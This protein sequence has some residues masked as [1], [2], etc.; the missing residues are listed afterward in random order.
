MSTMRT[1]KRAMLRNS[2]LP[3]RA[4]K[5]IA[6]KSRLYLDVTKRTDGNRGGNRGKK[7]GR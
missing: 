2:G 1:I 6:N 5:E 3:K 7:Y 4:I